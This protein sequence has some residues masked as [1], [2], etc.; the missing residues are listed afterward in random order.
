MCSSPAIGTVGGETVLFLF[1][2]AILALLQGLG[3]SAFKYMY[4]SWVRMLQKS[5]IEVITGV[6]KMGGSC[7]SCINYRIICTSASDVR[8]VMP[9]SCASHMFYCVKTCD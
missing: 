9:I 3:S 4:R 2:L 5:T 6:S 8:L 7:T 1:E